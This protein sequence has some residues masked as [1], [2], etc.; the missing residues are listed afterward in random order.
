MIAVLVIIFFV[1]LLWAYGKRQTANNGIYQ[2]TGQTTKRKRKRKPKVQSWEKQQKQIWKAKARSAMLKA[3]YAFLSIDEANDLFTY[4]HSTDEMKLLD[5]ILDA[6]LNGQA[7]VK[8]DRPLYE[9]MKSEKDL[10]R[11]M[12]KEKECQK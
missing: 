8:I 10:K 5:V 12:D 1:G 11:Q 2:P 6:K 4:N 9:R 7:Y 3:N